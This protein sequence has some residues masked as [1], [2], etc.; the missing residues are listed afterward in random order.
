LDWVDSQ[1]DLYG[2][3]HLSDGTLR[4]I[5]LMVGL[6]QPSPRLPSFVSID[7]PELGLHP[8]ALEVLSG[9]VRSLNGR[10]Q[11]LI[12]TQSAELLDFFE[13]GE[14]VVVERAAGE[15]IPEGSKQGSVFRRLDTKHLV[16]WLAEY[17]LSALYKRNLLGGRP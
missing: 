4:A 16:D 2:P 14:V 9:V 11:V 5:A 13:A 7:E 1:D 3:H 15:A 17:S 12:A 6:A 10:C 8:A